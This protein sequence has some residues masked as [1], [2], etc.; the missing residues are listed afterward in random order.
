MT[1][2]G[3]VIAK[4][5]NVSWILCIVILF[6]HTCSKLM[7]NVTLHSIMQE[8]MCLLQN[9]LALF[10]L[11]LHSM[12][13]R[14]SSGV[15]G[16]NRQD[17]L[18]FNSNKLHYFSNKSTLLVKWIPV[19]KSHKLSSFSDYHFTHIH[20]YIIG[21]YNPSIIITAFHATHVV[22]VINFMLEWWDLQFSI[23]S[24]RQIFKKIFMV[25]LLFLVY[26]S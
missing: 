5:T 25:S 12:G 11:I 23:D 19:K 20:A 17:A 13:N 18:Q 4:A 15:I 24:E 6:R 26:Y 9:Y 21:H 1:T 2:A 16:F 3:G 10:N 22:G 14:I 7:K 8:F